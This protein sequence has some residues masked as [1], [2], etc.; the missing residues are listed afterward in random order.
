MVR[1]TLAIVLALFA[2]T[3]AP[4]YAGG[5]TSVVLSAP[6]HVIAF[7][8]DDTQ[9]AELQRLADGAPGEPGEHAVGRFVR[10]TWLIHDMSV[11]RI[12]V[13]YPDAPGGPWIQSVNAFDGS[14]KP[15]W[16]RSSDPV[17][18]LRLLSD[19]KL[20][21][22][23]FDGGPALVDGYALPQPTPSPEAVPAQPVDAQTRATVSA[24]T[25]W[26][27]IIP[28]VLLGAAGV[29]LAL[30]RKQLD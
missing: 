29:A 16:R 7:G 20:L 17:K 13:I 18:L 3:A 8:Y 9:Y 12:D 1:R 25:G 19:L 26:R 24:F 30:R 11:W 22:G 6:P 2:L 10:A 27:W 4:A 5:P 23:R 28:G 21:T 14:G 15:V